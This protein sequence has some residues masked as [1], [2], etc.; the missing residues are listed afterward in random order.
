L[1]VQ[2]EKDDG[3]RSDLMYKRNLVVP[4][5]LGLIIVILLLNIDGFIYILSG[6]S[7]PH[8]DIPKIRE[9]VGQMPGMS[10]AHIYDST[11]WDETEIYITLDIANKGSLVLYNPTLESFT[12]NGPLILRQIG[13][14]TISPVLNFENPKG[15]SYLEI[16]SVNDI[17][18]KY[19]ELYKYLSLNA[20]RN[21][22]SKIH[23]CLKYNP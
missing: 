4:F 2:I 8:E 1:G 11:S 7:K 14:C 10:I 5:G 13:D 20:H 19:D 17:V 15:L 18:Q 12:S 3:F 16:Q 22:N 6:G 9:L 23:G 21:P